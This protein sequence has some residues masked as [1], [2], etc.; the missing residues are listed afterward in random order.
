[1]E[2][3]IAEMKVSDDLMKIHDTLKNMGYEMDTTFLA[4]YTMDK[5]KPVHSLT[6]L[7]DKND[8]T[9]EEVIIDKLDE[10]YRLYVMLRDKGKSCI[11]TESQADI[12]KKFVET[13]AE[14][15]A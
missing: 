12:I 15:T 2:P 6:Y 11:R 13:I 8:P 7:I 1:M 4:R 9:G 5:V 3:S 14:L 10:Y